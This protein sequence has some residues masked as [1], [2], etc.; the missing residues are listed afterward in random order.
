MGIFK[1][2]KDLGSMA[3]AAPDML[4]QTSQLTANAKVMQVQQQQAA[5]AMAN[6]AAPASRDRKSVV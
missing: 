4:S 1:G 3:K 2:L 5:V 6:F